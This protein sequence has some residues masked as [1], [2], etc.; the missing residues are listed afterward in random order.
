MQMNLDPK[1]NRPAENG[2]DNDP[3]LRDEDAR[4]PG[5]NTISSSKNDQAN[6]DLTDTAASD[7]REG[8]DDKRADTKFDEVD[9]EDEIE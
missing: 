7:F 5:T 1:R 9:P 2:T 3:N 4:Q 8:Q 6:E